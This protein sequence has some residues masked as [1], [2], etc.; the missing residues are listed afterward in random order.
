MITSIAEQTNLLALNATIEAARAGEAGKGFAVVASEVKDLAQETAQA[1]EDIARRVQAIQAD[2]AA[3]STRSRRS[4]RSSSGSTTTRRRSPRRSR[5]RPRRRARWTATSPRRPTRLDEHRRRPSPASPRRRRT[6]TTAWASRGIPRT[7]WPG[8]PANSEPGV[9]VPRVR[10]PREPERAVGKNRHRWPRRRNDC[11]WRGV[12]HY[13][14][15]STG[16]RLEEVPSVLDPHGLYELADDLPA[17]DRPVLIQALDRLRRRGQRDPARPRAPAGQLDGRVVATFD[18]DQLLDYRS[19]RPA[20]DLRRGPLGELRGAEPRP[21][22][23]ARPAR[24]PVPDAR[25]PRAGPAVGAVH[26]RGHRPHRAVRRTAHRR[27]ERDPDGRA[28]H[29]SGRR[30]RAR[31]RPRADR[32]LRA[33]AAAGAG[34][35]QRGEPAGVPAR[36]GRPRRDGL[37]R[38][39]AALPGAEHLSRRP[40]S[41][42]STRSPR[43][44]AWCCRPTSCA[45][46]PSWCAWRWTSR[47]P[48]PRRRP[49]WSPRWSSSTTRSC[50]GREGNLLAGAT[51]PL[52][53]AEELGAE[54][55]RF[56]AEQS[57]D[58]END[59]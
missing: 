20:D 8:W 44:P 46:P 5:S 59:S 42:C 52:P 22:P 28:A 2:T 38:A 7:T 27:P 49:R 37:R 35:G 51:G 9:A 19:R 56:L 47:W 57:K 12:C 41:C 23:G 29:P 58:N 40:P 18:L 11:R 36:Q 16:V 34:A 21:A 39:R 54:L 15:V 17:L 25:R 6:P 45:R 31:H 50:R 14:S 4:P 32:R 26:R 48:R 55:E 24:H 53:T 30:H 3:R 43:R 10:L 1:T 13:R 33:V